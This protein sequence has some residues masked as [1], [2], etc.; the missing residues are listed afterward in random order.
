MEC[1]HLKIATQLLEKRENKSYKDVC[2]NGEFP[3]LLELGT[4]KEY[5]R[6]IL[7]N[8]VTNTTLNMKCL[9][10]CDMPKDNVY[11]RYQDKV[12]CK[13]CTPSHNVIEKTIMTF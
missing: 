12:I 5:V 13:K 9:D 7:K 2:E 1:D 10:I 11:E 3:T 6:N 4:N 8:T